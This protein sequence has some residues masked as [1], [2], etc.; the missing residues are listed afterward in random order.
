MCTSSGIGCL[1]TEQLK[2]NKIILT[3][4]CDYTEETWYPCRLTGIKHVYR[5]FSMIEVSS[6]A[7][8]EPLVLGLHRCHTANCLPGWTMVDGRWRG[9][10]KWKRVLPW[11]VIDSSLFWSR[12]LCVGKEVQKSP[13]P[14]SRLY[15][16][17]VVIF[18]QLSRLS[19]VE[20]WSTLASFI[21]PTVSIFYFFHFSL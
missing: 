13:P 19:G 16:E 12:R 18:H 10:R 9:G 2:N 6:I 14:P 11:I 3:A 4:L 17:C 15:S 5:H 21:V 8:K 1:I 20:E 7:T